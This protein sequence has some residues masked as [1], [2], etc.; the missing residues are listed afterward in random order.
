MNIRQYRGYN[1]YL[2]EQVD[3]YFQGE[4]I[5]TVADVATATQTIDGWMEAK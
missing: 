2:G 4:R 5:D 3:I 1:L